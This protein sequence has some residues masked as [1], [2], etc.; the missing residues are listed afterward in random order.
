MS[1]ALCLALPSN[2]HAQSYT[3]SVLYAPQAIS[4][5]INIYAP[6][7]QASDGNFYGVATANNS[8]GSTIFRVSPSGQPALIYNFPTVPDQTRIGLTEGSDGNLYGVLTTGGDASNYND[9][10]IFKISLP[11]GTESTLYTFCA[12]QQTNGNCVGGFEPD[13]VLVEG[14]DGNFY[15]TTVAGGANGYGTIFSI[16][17]AGTL[18]TLYNFCSQGGSACT[19][20]VTPEAGLVEG[21]DGN[22]YGTAAEG[23]SA[24]P[25]NASTTPGCGVIFKITP[26]GSY[27][28]VYSFTGGSDGAFPGSRLVEGADGSFYGT[29]ELAA[30]SSPPPQIV[31]KVTTSGTLTPVYTLANGSEGMEDGLVLASDG[32][33]YGTEYSGGSNGAGSVYQ[34]TPE[35]VAKA[36]YSF[37]NTPD[38]A[39][40]DTQPM[41]G[42]DGNLYGTT[43]S[44]GNSLGNGT[45]ASGTVWKLSVSPALEPPVALSFSSQ[46]VAPGQ[47]VTLNWSVANAYSTSL[48]QCYAFIQ[49]APTGAGTWTG[50]QSG[51]F[52][53]TQ[54]PPYSGSATI[55]PTTDGTYTY[56]LTCGGMESGFATLTVSTPTT[57]VIKTSS[58]PAGTVGVAY[59]QSLAASGGVSPY[60]WSISS[61]R[62]PAGL[63][64]GA[65]NGVI[66]GTPTAAATFNFTIDVKDSEST[67]QSVT[68]GLTITINPSSQ[69]APTV[70]LSASPSSGISYGQSVTLTASETPSYG[71]AQG[72]SWSVYDGAT[73]LVTGALPNVPN[74]GYTMTTQPLSVGQH[75]FKAIYSTTN[76]AYSSGTSNTV[77]IMVGKSMPTITWSTPSPI[78]QGTALSSAQLDASAS[79]TGT[80]A[81]NPPA[82]TVLSAGTQTLS[83]TFTPADTTDYSTATASVTLTVNPA[84]PALTISPT[85]LTFAAQDTG[86]TSPSQ[87]LTLTN[88]GT[89]ALSIAS[90]AASGDFAETNTCGTSLAA[91]ANCT[92]SVTFSPTTG[93]T[94]TGTLTI[95]DNASG[96]PQTIALSG[97]GSAVSVS[98]S[99]TSLS[100]SSQGGSATA[101]IQLSAA[102]GFSGTVNLACAVAYQGSGTATDAPACTINPAQQQVSGTG[103]DSS[104]LTVNTTAS[105]SATLENHPFLPFGGGALAA[106]LIFTGMPRKRLRNLGLLV[107]LAIVVIGGA[108]GCGGSSS[109]TGSNPGTTTGSYKVTVIATSGTVSASMT[110]PLTVQ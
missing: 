84:A 45:Y 36:V 35:G 56:A 107:I 110:I 103:A 29:T 12:S 26:S 67:P 62:L 108:V 95:T 57:L 28:V 86:S 60:A 17:P 80:F 106:L 53:A 88:S 61:G 9:G 19:D 15:G 96:S 65:T 79:V 105:G 38:G 7:I 32:N 41:Q 46:T 8:T 16:T 75:T 20:G 85:S 44:G 24:C 59:S 31:F 3:E 71:I 25:A 76:S 90:I 66:S 81:Y 23:G 52:S 94:R 27:S 48:Q 70:A 11:S 73:A 72:Y 98:S 39:S 1:I 2:M 109:T 99:T 83:V 87:T 64:L 74:N 13:G 68:A 92:V 49:G 51:T 30:G 18:T 5:G 93:G 40:P 100:I 77:N 89:A 50:L 37:S 34:L 22:F 102:G 55:T 101:T 63:S 58:L 6:V 14:S 42:A 43:L 104:T 91:S 21:S 33:F 54:N 78:V 47:S 10:L 97:S 82:G 4:D 69:P